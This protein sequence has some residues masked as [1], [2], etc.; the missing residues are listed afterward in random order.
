[1]KKFLT[2]LLATCLM[3]NA[4][5][6]TMGDVQKIKND[7][8]A[9]ITSFSKRD[10]E[11]ILQQ[12]NDQNEIVKIQQVF[13]ATVLDF[14]NDDSSKQCEADFFSRLVIN[15]KAANLRN[16]KDSIDDH[17]KLLRTLNYIDD[18]L[19]DVV[20]SINDDAEK[21]SKL[22]LK[23]PFRKSMVKHEDRLEK[24]N[25]EDLYFAF[26]SWPDEKN[27]C[28]TQEFIR[29]K[30]S[31]T[32]PNNEKEKVKWKYLGT[33][34]EKAFE[35]K[36]ISLETFNKLEFFRT[37]S[38]FEK[39]YIWLN[40]YIKIVLNAKNRMIP[41]T[42]SYE[43]KNL[44]AE[45]KFSTEKLKR[46]STLTRR[47]S[48]YK[49]YNETQILLLAQ[50]MQKA[51]RRMGVDVDTITKAPYL[52]QEFE[53][54][55]ENGERETYVEKTEIDPQSQYNLARRLMRKDIVDLQMMSIFNRIDVTY[56]D[57]VMA[58]LEVGYIS[59]EDIEFVVAYDDLWNP[60]TSK[61]ER[62]S[63]FIFKVAGYT[64]FFLPTPFNIAA[65]LAL[66]IVEGIVDRNFKTGASNDNP[67]TFIE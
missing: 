34:N 8:E 66:G 49:K 41:I 15:L 26:K 6:F 24:N 57:I 33:L 67:G 56:E 64:S 13:Y 61:Y 20:S 22:D 29:L 4:F 51:S 35:K 55:K 54:L 63:G 37:K 16:D 18:I 47:K 10:K 62:M 52:I 28:S 23:K 39:R 32:I 12:Y 48:L 11:N 53:L 1:M 40:D 50:V 43:V 44:D 30:E 42:K 5:A 31:V 9:V 3:N 19:Y 7:K 21:L 46:F 36:L 2:V 45:S 14:I 59:L 27:R 60:T 65:S 58:S 38:N 17:L 25:V